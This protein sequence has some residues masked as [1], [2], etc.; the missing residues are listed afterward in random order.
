MKALEKYRVFEFK[1]ED[2]D[3]SQGVIRGFAST[4]GNIDLGDDVVDQ[5]AF[6]KTLQENRGIVPILADHDPSKQIG[7]NV[8]AE[9]TKD[10]LYVEGKLNLQ[11]SELAREKYGLVK[12][13]L[14]LGAK[15]GLSIGYSVIKSMPDKERPAVRRLKEVKLY[16]Y[17]IVTFPMNTA[18]MITAAKNWQEEIKKENFVD[19][20]KQ[21]SKEL[22]I[23][24]AFLVEALL[25]KEAA[26]TDIIEDPAASQSLDRLINS[27][28]IK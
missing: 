21:K 13:A 7:W 16:E 3:A 15:M 18:A 6:K 20:I 9:E 10:G 24:Q 5:G 25:K 1:L 26:L 2:G 27:L 12:Q 23:S 11:H 8:R 4:F 17:S 19:F 22:G 28:T 14:D